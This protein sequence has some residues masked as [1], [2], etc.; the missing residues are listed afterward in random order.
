MGCCDSKDKPKREE[1]QTVSFSCPSCQNKG[2]K[3]QTIT[4]QALL[5]DCCKEKINVE[6]QYKFCKNSDCETVYFSADTSHYFLK[7]ELTV[8]ATLKDEGLEV[9]VCYCFGHTRASVLDEIKRTGKSTVLEDI[10]A[11]MK[12][13]GCFCETSNPQGG[14]CLGNVISWI[15]E[16]KKL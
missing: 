15:A 10:K 9:N 3:V 8:K 11:K 13:P 12:D 5:K 1:D 4:L 6:L 16:A 7:D 2:V 14:C